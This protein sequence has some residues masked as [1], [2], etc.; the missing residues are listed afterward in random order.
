MAPAPP[1][2]APAK[3]APPE[4]KVGDVVRLRSGGLHMTVF[5]VQTPFHVRV[6]WAGY[7]DIQKADFLSAVLEK[8]P[9]AILAL[10]RRAEDDPIPF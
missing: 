7:H 1:K 2:V 3:A 6:G 10:S 5:E 4:F 9:D 8:V